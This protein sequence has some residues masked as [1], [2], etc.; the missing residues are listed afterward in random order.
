MKALLPV[1][2]LLCSCSTAGRI[3]PDGSIEGPTSFL[4][5]QVAKDVVIKSS[6]GSLSVGAYATHNPDRQLTKTIGATVLGIAAFKSADHINDNATSTDN[7]NAGSQ[8]AALVKGTK[9][10]NV[11]PLNPNGVAP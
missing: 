4:G 10:P 8:G 5:E 1:A 11:I 2:L 7:I 3:R 9:D 6:L